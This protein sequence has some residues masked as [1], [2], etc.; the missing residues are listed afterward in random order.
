MHH[1]LLIED[2]DLLSLALTIALRT[3]PEVTVDYAPNGLEGLEAYARQRPDL[4]IVDYMMP[5]I[6]GLDVIRELRRQGSTIPIL[7]LTAYDSP[8][9]RQD[10]RAAGATDVMAKPFLLDDVRDVVAFFLAAGASSPRPEAELEHGGTVRLRG[11][12]AV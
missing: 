6:S 2:D 1:L 10:A 8:P 9:L 7:M 4:V 12:S 5:D 3:I 11:V